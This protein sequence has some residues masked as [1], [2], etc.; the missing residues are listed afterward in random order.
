LPNEIRDVLV[1]TGNEKFD[2]AVL[3]QTD[4]DGKPKRY[5]RQV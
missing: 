1:P 2:A 4:A 5:G 3:H